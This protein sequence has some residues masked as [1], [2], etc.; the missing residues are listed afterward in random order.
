MDTPSALSVEDVEFFALSAHEWRISDRRHPRHDIVALLGFVARKD[1][2]FYVTRM[3]HPLEATR[4]GSLDQVAEF[5]ASGIE[6]ASGS[7]PEF[8]RG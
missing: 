7:Q 8:T 5:F 1:G 4:F 2:D 6:N 3:D